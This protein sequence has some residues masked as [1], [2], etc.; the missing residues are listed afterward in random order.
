MFPHNDYIL[1]ETQRMH[2]ED[3]LHAATV[4]RTLR[5]AR[6]THTNWLDLGLAAIGR[7]MVDFGRRLESRGAVGLHS[8]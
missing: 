1:V 6:P 7:V 4:E 8:A 5:L 3:M 2:R